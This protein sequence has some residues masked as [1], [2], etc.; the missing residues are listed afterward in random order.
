MKGT[1]RRL[2]T[3]KAKQ[4]SLAKKQ[5]FLEKNTKWVKF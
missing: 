5:K 1:R 4:E 2:Q 3:Q